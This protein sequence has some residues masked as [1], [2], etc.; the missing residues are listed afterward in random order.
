MKPRSL[1]LTA[2]MP[3]AAVTSLRAAPTEIARESFE[4]APGSI[5]FST[6][7]AQFIETAFNPQSDYFSVI[8]NNGSKISG[9]RTIPG[10]DGAS[11]FAAEDCDTART[12]PAVAGPQ[13]VSLTT[14]AVNI[15]GKINTQVRLLM[16][17]PGRDT[18]GTVTLNEY[19][20]FSNAPLFIN[21]LRVEASIDGGPFQ[22]IVQ[23]SPTVVDAITTLS[24]DADGNNV[25]NDVNPIPTNPTV[26]N[27]TLQEG[28]YSIPTGNTVAIRMT[29]ESDA[30][31]ELICFDN[32]RIFGESAAT[33][34]PSIAGVPGTPLVFTEGGAAAAIAPA[35]TVTD[36]DSA[37]L[38][39]A[40]VVITQA[41]V[42]GEDVLAATPSG[43]LGAGNISYT[44][45]TGTLT[46]T[47][48]ATVANYQAVLRSV[49]Y[50]NTNNTNPSTNLRRVTFS[51]T[52]GTNP[53]NAPVRDINVVDT[54]ATQA[55]PFVES[56][57]TD[58]RG[59]RY[60]VEGG[61]SN[62]PSM[63]ARYQPGGVSGLDGTFAW[64]VENVDDNPDLTDLI[65]FNLNAAGLANITGE[66]RAGATGGA[67]YDTGDFLRVEVSADG[68]PFQNVLAF[69]SDG[70]AS[71]SMRHDTTPGDVNNVGDGALLTSTLQNFT[72][73]LPSANTLTVRIR[74]FSN[75]V[76]EHIVFD[77]LAV[78][79]TPVTFDIS[80]ASSGAE[81]AG[82]RNFTV[83]RNISSGADTVTYTTNSGTANSAD[84][85]A[86]TSTVN[87]ADGETTRPISINITPDNIV[88]LDE[89]FTVTLSS[90]TRGTIIGSPGTGTITNDD[91]SVVTLT[92]GVVTEGDTGTAAMNFAVSLSN[93][94][95]VPVSFNR[96]TLATGSA[97]SGT[98]FTAVAATATTIPAL[99][100]SGSFAVNAIGDHLPE[101]TETV[102]VELSALS[103]SGR[104]VTFA[105]GGAAHT[106]S[107]GIQDDDPL[108]IAATGSASCGVGSSAKVTIA[109]L[110]AAATGGEGRPLSLVSVQATATSGGGSAAVSGAWVTYVPAPGFSGADS[111]TYVITDGFQNATGTINVV[112]SNGIGQT[113]NI[114]GITP[115]GAGNNL[116]ALGIPGRTYRWQTS[117]NLV[118]WSN[119]GSAIV[120]PAS[121]VV[122]AND[123]GPLPPTRFYRMVQP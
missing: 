14:N 50:R 84:F 10:G 40:S 61:F 113:V 95:D 13:E 119:L 74:A 93:P 112:V 100:T 78:Q 60:A 18:A 65:T 2:M 97:T 49:T 110:L 96:A 25:G 53:S 45:A 82:P 43:A 105:G 20:N 26:L 76:G 11:I 99:Q 27:A 85:T 118:T 114:M 116:L 46:I 47:G 32:I 72:F 86:V 66:L 79:G 68:G 81:N 19:E 7:V 52:D 94:V 22:R 108:I 3:M 62:P 9:S 16:A 57:E 69:H 123:P 77:R 121:G 6:S 12:S 23:F 120:C 89:T 98:D 55:I 73:N 67:V 101:S 115:A 104:A 38:T 70:A 56:W 88:E 36:S 17:A 41:L 35:L 5:G 42:P 48:S 21:K 80:S 37:N 1:L 28:I 34:P 15:A 109:S 111:F 117:S 75:I 33:N 87:F 103:A 92:G 106:A 102:P 44:P 58:G 54:I 90:P 29:L 30:T 31:G 51:T 64:G 83:T 122:S 71:A 4:G 8:P 59:T 91:S 39:S 107:G 24:Y 63:F